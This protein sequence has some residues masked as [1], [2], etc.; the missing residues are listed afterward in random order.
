MKKQFSHVSAEGRLVK[1]IK[2]LEAYEKNLE[3]ELEKV[4]TSKEI[5]TTILENLGGM[6]NE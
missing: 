1:E 5:K 6:G 2:E 4:K 3:L